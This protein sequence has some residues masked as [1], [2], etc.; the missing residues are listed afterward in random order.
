[1][2]RVIGKF[3]KF[4]KREWK[5][6]FRYGVRL[7]VEDVFY[8][9]NRLFGNCESSRLDEMGSYWFGVRC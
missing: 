1:N 3:R 2:L 5:E 4:G 6:V 7:R 9:I 8:R